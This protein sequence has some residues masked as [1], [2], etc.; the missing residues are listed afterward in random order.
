MIGV[1]TVVGAGGG[2]GG[3]LGAPFSPFGGVG[4][5]VGIGG[6]PWFWAL[7]SGTVQSRNARQRLSSNCRTAKDIT[8]KLYITFYFNPFNLLAY[9][10]FS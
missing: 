1:S 5:A 8:R 10:S 4:A 2:P 6:T 7:M 9:I 3:P